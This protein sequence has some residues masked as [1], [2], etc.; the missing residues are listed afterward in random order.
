MRITQ[1]DNCIKIEDYGSFDLGL[2]LDCGQAFRWKQNEN[3]I[4]CGIAG[5][6]YLEAEQKDGALY[7]YTS[8]QDF[9][10]FWRSYLDL[11]FDYEACCRRL[12]EEENLRKAV[13]QCKGIHILRQEPWEAIC[14]FIISSNNN[15]P[16]I[17]GIIERLCESF[18]DR[19]ENGYTF[20]AAERLAELT[21]EDLAP[22]RAGFRARYIIDAAQ[23]VAAGEIDFEKINAMPIEYGRAEL[24]KICGVGAKVAECALLY[25]FYKTEAFPIDVWVKRIMEEMYPDGFPKCADGVQ[26]IAQQYLFHWRRNYF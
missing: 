2:S 24:T 6:K 15:I 10:S 1:T 13:E 21:A 19:L 23:K 14:S 17:K 5:G 26:G 8:R 3:G 25:G 4:W 9:D 16:R 11:D 22:L 7:L 20:P 12:A 18:G